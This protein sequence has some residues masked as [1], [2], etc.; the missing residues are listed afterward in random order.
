[1][2]ASLLRDKISESGLTIYDPLHSYPDLF[3][4]PDQL[5]ELLAADLVGLSLANLPLRTRSKVVK[6]YVCQALGYPVPKSFKKTKPRFPGQNFDTYAQKS[7]NLQ[8]W[9]EEISPSRRY[10]VIIVDD[11]DTISGIHVLGGETLAEYDTT[12]ILTSKYQAKSVK[13]VIASTL[14]SPLDTPLIQRILAS[15]TQDIH[16]KFMPIADVFERLKSL[17]ATTIVD[18]GI[19][20]ER[21]RGDSLHNAVKNCLDASDSRDSGQFPDIREQLLEIKLQTSPTIDLGLVTPDSTSQLSMNIEIRHCDVRY[22]VFYGTCEGQLIHLDNVVLTTG[23]SFFTFFQ[24]FEG[25]VQNKKL[26][27]HLP[28]SYFR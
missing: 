16:K 26:Q 12:G 21:N 8:I 2:N 14:V 9:N 5:K 24:R 18:P 28:D 10:V 6:T 15:A 1:M 7:N 11:S 13:P 22:A 23:E 17:I 20:Q 19:D 25:M 4:T 3:L 27:I